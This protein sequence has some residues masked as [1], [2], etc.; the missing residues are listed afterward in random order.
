MKVNLV[1]TREVAFWIFVRITVLMCFALEITLHNLGERSMAI[2]A[3]L[4][5]INVS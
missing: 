4:F 5:L 3:L 1:N 2:M